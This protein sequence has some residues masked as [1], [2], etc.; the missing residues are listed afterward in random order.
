MNHLVQQNESSRAVTL[1]CVDCD[2]FATI[3]REGY[4]DHETRIIIQPVV[5]M[6]KWSHQDPTLVAAAEHV[7]RSTWR[8]LR[9]Y[10][11]K[12]VSP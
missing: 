4:L 3:G 5:D 8:R 7:E 6:V 12:G 11:T 10:L 2:W 9:D 1:R